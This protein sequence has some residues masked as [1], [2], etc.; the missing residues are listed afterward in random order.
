VNDLQLQSR[1]VRL[2]APIWTLQERI[3]KTA[4]PARRLSLLAAAWLLLVCG[5]RSGLAQSQSSVP[6]DDTQSWT[7]VQ[8]IFPIHE[9]VDLGILSQFRIGRDIS[10]FV[11]ERAGV[12][13]SFKLNKYLTFS[14]A[15][16]YIATQPIRG[17][18]AHEN[19]LMF[20]GTV[21]WPVGRFTFIDRNQIERRLRRPINS[22]RYRNRLQIEHPVKISGSVFQPYISDEVFYDWNLHAWVRNRFAVGVSKA[23]TRWLTG[24]LYYMRQN[25]GR[26]RPGDLHVIGSGLRIRLF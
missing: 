3:F 18:K 15:Y 5:A 16:L 22:T 21:R 10:A 1:G 6:Q 8:V 13:L 24:E 7:D 17:L 14:P 2:R 12:S 26:S 9:K 20:T 19:R 4:G 25:D 23:L 11:D